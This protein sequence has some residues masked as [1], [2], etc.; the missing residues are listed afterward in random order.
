MSNTGYNNPDNSE[1]LLIASIEVCPIIS[2]RVM[3]LDFIQMLLHI[4]V[5]DI[6]FQRTN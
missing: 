6:V 1:Q 2:I 4:I 5:N 3:Y